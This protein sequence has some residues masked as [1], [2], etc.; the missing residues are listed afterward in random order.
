MKSRLLL[1]AVAALFAASFAAIAADVPAAPAEKAPVVKKKVRPHSHAE[2]NKQ[3]TAAP[4][5]SAPAEEAKK[6]LHDHMKEHKQ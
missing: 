5:K 2:A 4:E 6:P 3:G 1:S